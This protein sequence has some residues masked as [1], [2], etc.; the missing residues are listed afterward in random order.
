MKLM[1]QT[2][3]TYA[4]HNLTNEF[5]TENEGIQL[6]NVAMTIVN[7]H[8]EEG[9]MTGDIAPDKD[10][11]DLMIQFLDDDYQPLPFTYDQLIAHV[12]DNG[13]SFTNNGYGT[14]ITRIHGER[15]NPDKHFIGLPAN[16][17]EIHHV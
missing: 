9:C 14:I 1:I 15:Y 10:D 11:T 5:L 7:A 17:G 16:K 4:A 13:G 3:N 12:E 6:A 8:I 2:V